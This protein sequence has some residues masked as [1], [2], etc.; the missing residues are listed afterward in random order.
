VPEL[1]EVETIVRDL[2]EVMVGRR[3]VKA[4]V[5]VAKMADCGPRKFAGLVAGRTILSSDRRAKYILLGLSGG[6]RLVVHL[7]MTGQFLIGSIPKNWPEHVHAIFELED[8]EALLYRDMRK[9]GRLYAF[10]EGNFEEW[11]RSKNLGPEPLEMAADE[12][13]LLLAGRRGRIKPLLLDQTFLAGLGNIYA[14]EALFAA[15]VHPLFPAER[16]S[17]DKALKLHREIVR[18]L[19]AA[20]GQRGS[21]TRNYQGLKGA[22]GR[23]QNLHLVYGKGGEA[24]PHCGQAIV[25]TVVGGRGTHF[26]P[27]CQPAPS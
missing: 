16:V 24:C 20:I 11:L 5:D 25:R 19:T 7:K 26:C 13:A 6:V 2:R 12:F 14:D 17:R 3:I 4:R 1:P 18:I 8:G 10:T 21:T 9:F 23:F 22:A 27:C 15:G